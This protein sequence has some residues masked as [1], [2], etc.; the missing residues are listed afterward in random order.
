MEVSLSRRFTRMR[1][2]GICFSYHLFCWLSTK[3]TL[4]RSYLVAVTP[5]TNVTG[6]PIRDVGVVVG[7]WLSLDFKTGAHFGGVSNRGDAMSKCGSVTYI[8]VVIPVV[9]GV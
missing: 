1:E 7:L 6:L 5:V 9:A 8:P 4:R 3:V 2:D